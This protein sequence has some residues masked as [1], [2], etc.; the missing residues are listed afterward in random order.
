MNH[1]YPAIQLVR[2][3]KRFDKVTACDGI[4][5]EVNRGEILALL[6]EN[7][8]GK[9]TLTNM[10][11]GIYQPDAG[12]IVLDGQPVKIRSPRDSI[13]LGVGMIHQ[14]FKL[15]EV[16]TA[17]ENI[18]LG[19]P[20][21]L[22]MQPEETIKVFGIQVDLNKKV[23]KM[24]V[25]EKQAV[26]ILK[27]LCRGAD[28][29]ILDEPTAVLTPQ[30]IDTL[31]DALRRMR[32][33]GKAIIIITHKLEEV[34]DISDRV[35][36]LRR[37]TQVGSVLTSATDR[38]HLTELMVGRPINLDIQ[39]LDM[40][41]GKTLL[42]VSKLSVND[43]IGRPLIQDISFELR[44]GE[45]LGIAGVAGSGQKALCETISG[46]EKPIHGTIQLEDQHIEGLSPREISKRGVSM[47]FIP[48]DRL[49]MGLVGGMNI[50]DNLL[51]KSYKDQKGFFL[52]R[53]AARKEAIEMVKRLQIATP[54]IH[55]KLSK[56]SGGNVQ[57]V[58]LGREINLSPKVLITA[59]PVRGLDIGAS[60]TIYDMLNEQ[61]QKGVGIL[62]VGEDL[63]VLLSFCDRIMVL[64]QGKVSAIVDSRF[65]TKALLGMKMTGLVTDKEDDYA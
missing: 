52:S 27:V 50:P 60:M 61:K 20:N 30:E 4:D 3:T 38:Y 19:Q 53:K 35:T 31:F 43:D 41:M 48:E 1:L 46:I 25:S 64:C 24:S 13:R 32:Q 54:G 2:L 29:L 57:K 7:G 16:L 62:F 63:D 39:H 47:A 55:I 17:R 18:M 56:L 12:Q 36:V 45:I 59:Y 42:T 37:G 11:S 28:K 44:A 9:T 6:G 8:S 33:E 26:E 58:L 10:L 49:G 51:L 5:L 23:Y 65:A 34:M 15:V 22:T 21:T 14:H 40:P